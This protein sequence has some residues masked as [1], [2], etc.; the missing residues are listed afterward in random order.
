MSK[1]LC[2]WNGSWKKCSID[3]LSFINVIIFRRSLTCFIS[4]FSEF[5]M[6]KL[7]KRV[8]GVLFVNNKQN[9]S[10]KKQ[11]I[12]IYLH[13]PIWGISHWRWGSCNSARWFLIYKISRFNYSFL[14][15]TVWTI[16]K[17]TPPPV[18]PP[19]LLSRPLMLCNTA[20]SKPNLRL[21]RSNIS[22]SYE[23]LVIKRYTFTAL[24]W[25]MRWQRAWACKVYKN[26]GNCTEHIICFNIYTLVWQTALLKWLIKMRFNK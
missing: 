6:A 7:E 5:K 8:D 1:L 22:R 4:S 18:P 25:P 11:V 15:Q 17:L 24:F 13:L 12:I 23:F 26:W 14:F 20:L 10:I 3:L 2:Y 16:L 9:T 19:R 21:A